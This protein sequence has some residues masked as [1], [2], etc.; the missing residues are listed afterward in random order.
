MKYIFLKNGVAIGFANCVD[1][2]VDLDAVVAKP[3]VVAGYIMPAD[4]DQCKEWDARMVET[5]TLRSKG[6]TADDTTTESRISALELAVAT[7]MRNKTASKDA[8]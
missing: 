4:D 5:Q 6:F 2:I 3:H 7:L 1:D 8:K